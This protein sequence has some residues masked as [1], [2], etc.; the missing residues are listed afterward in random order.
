MPQAA[1][2][3]KLPNG[4]APPAGYTLYKTLRD[5][6]IYHKKVN[7]PAQAQPEVDALAEMFRGLRVAAEVNQVDDLA[8]ALGAL[9]MGGKRRRGTRRA[10]RNNRKTLRR[11]RA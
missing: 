7:A 2:V 1:I 9:G 10:R 6:S 4:V 8:A 3:I 5:K 11:R